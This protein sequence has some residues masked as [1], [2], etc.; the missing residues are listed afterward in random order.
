[1]TECTEGVEAFLQE[2]GWT[3]LADD[4]TKS[5][6]ESSSNP[7]LGIEIVRV[8]LAVIE[9]DSLSEPKEDYMSP[10][11]LASKSLTPTS[12]VSALELPI[13][14]AQL[15]IELL[16]R[17]PRNVRKEYKSHAQ[18]L[19]ETSERLLMESDLREDDRDGLMEVVEGL[20]GLGYH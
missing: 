18:G 10:I 16:I 12:H 4:L 20:S 1:M 2:E 7:A 11:K 6:Q 15:A 19:L 13:A 8:L 14:V 17:V 5:L 9:S 3:P